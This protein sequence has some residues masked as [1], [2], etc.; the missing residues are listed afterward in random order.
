MNLLTVKSRLITPSPFFFT[1]PN[2]FFLVAFCLFA[3]ISCTAPQKVGATQ[4]TVDTTAY[5]SLLW[6]ISGNGLQ[7]PSYL[8]G[9]VH[10]IPAKDYAFSDLA[11]ACLAQS[12]QLCLEINIDDPEMVTAAFRAYLPEG[13][14]LQSLLTAADYALLTQT[15]QTQ[16][17][18]I[19][20]V[21]NMKPILISSLLLERGS[22]EPLLTYESE[23]VTAARVQRKPIIALESPLAQMTMLDSI[24]LAAQTEMLLQTLKNGGSELDELV[25][26]YKTQNIDSIYAFIQSK[27]NEG[28]A[29]NRVLLT[30]RNAAWL[31]LID[32]AAH[33]KTTFFAIG[34]GHLGGKMGLVRR[35]RKAGFVVK[36]LR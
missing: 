14:S 8:F 29:F 34:A 32:A 35:L 15:L 28:D 11:K 5:N 23:L 10:L 31:P 7:K 24:P 1:A 17:L 25:A 33:E 16:N 21:K 36:A 13:T 6:Q 27:T 4:A 18:S 12:K 30:R 20:L 26:H 19:D 9:T 2:T 22:K 3:Q